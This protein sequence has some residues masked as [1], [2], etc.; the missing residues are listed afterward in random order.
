M[1]PP[2]DAS[3]PAPDLGDPRLKFPHCA[4]VGVLA[5]LA[6]DAVYTGEP[7]G[8]RYDVDD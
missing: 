8:A 4:N 3:D 7:S 5:P 2:R 6:A 1:T